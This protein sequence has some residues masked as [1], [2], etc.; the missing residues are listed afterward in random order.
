[1]TLVERIIT[2]RVA[3][4][5]QID[6]PCGR[7]LDRMGWGGLGRPEWGRVGGMVAKGSKHVQ[8]VGP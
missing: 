5:D 4:I 3:T 6:Q 7:A 2:D 8:S 1:M